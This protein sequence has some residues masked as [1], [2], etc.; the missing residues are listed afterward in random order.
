MGNVA[1]SADILAA[2]W[3]KPSF[4]TPL[5]MVLEGK[6]RLRICFIAVPLGLPK[7]PSYCAVRSLYAVQLKEHG[8]GEYSRSLPWSIAWDLQVEKK[9]E[10]WS[11]CGYFILVSRE[12]PYRLCQVHQIISH[13][14]P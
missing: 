10:D 11:S 12:Y 8:N 4:A 6:M 5:L 1:A 13:G 3:R 2:D 9:S 14:Q 7:T